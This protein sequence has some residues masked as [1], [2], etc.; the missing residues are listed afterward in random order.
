VLWQRR[1]RGFL[2]LEYDGEELESS[3]VPRAVVWLRGMLAKDEF[4]AAALEA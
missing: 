2:S 1:Y 4:K 3:A